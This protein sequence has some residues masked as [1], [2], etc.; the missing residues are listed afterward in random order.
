MFNEPWDHEKEER[1][2]EGTVREK[3]VEEVED[4]SSREGRRRKRWMRT[5]W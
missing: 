3:E 4:S 2:S 5:V 1:Q